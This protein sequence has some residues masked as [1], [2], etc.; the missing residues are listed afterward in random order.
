MEDLQ[1][2][3][4]ADTEPIPGYRL[5]HPL[6][7]GGFGEVWKCEAPGGLLKAIKFVHGGTHLLDDNAPAEEELRAVERVKAIR[8][9]FMLTMERVESVGGELVIVMELAD[10]SL[11]ELLQ[12]C[13]KAGLPGIPR[14]ALLAYLREAAEVLDVMN[15]RHSLQHLD[16]KPRNLFLVSNHVKVG[17]FGLVSSLSGL[18]KIELAAITP[19]Y[20]SPEVFQGSISRHSDQYSLAIVYQELLTGTLP[21]V[22]K[23]ARQLLMAHTLSEPNLQPLPEC[24]RAIV[25]RAL[26][27]NPEERFPSCSDFLSALAAGR[28]EVVTTSTEFVSRTEPIESPRQETRR[29]PSVKTVQTRCAK[30]TGNGILHGLELISRT[31]L[32]EVWKGQDSNGSPRTIKVLFGGPNPG[33]A[34]VERLG[35]LRHPVLAP[36]EILQHSPGR[37][38]LSSPPGEQTLRDVLQAYQNE[39]QPGIPRDKL[40]DWLRAAAE[41]LFYLNQKYGLQ[42]LGLNPRCLLLDHDRLLLADFGIAQLVWLPVG[43]SLT[44]LNGRYSAPE[45][46]SNRLGPAA[47][48]YSLALIYHELLTGTLPAQRA[49]GLSLDR[50]PETDRPL[51]ARAL[52]ADP[53]QRWASAVDLITALEQVG[54]DAKV[55]LPVGALTK[56]IKP[57]PTRNMPQLPRAKPTDESGEL[58]RARF[59]T[60]LTVDLIRQRIETFRQQWNATLRRSDAHEFAFQMP[61]PRSLWQRWTGK[62]PGLDIQIGMGAANPSGHSGIQVRTEVRMDLIPRDC[63]RDQTHELLKV[64]GPLLV[65]SLRTHL[66]VGQNG[67]CQERLPWHY[68]LKLCSILDNQQLG[69]PIECQGKDIS[70]NGIG[71]YL[72]GQLPSSQV[73]LILPP[74][75][76]TPE[77]SIPARIVRVQGCG[78]GWYEVGAVLLPPDELPPEQEEPTEGESA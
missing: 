1:Y 18:G 56:R 40:L 48:Q 53:A 33:D 29:L 4:R 62:Q 42:H 6:G 65:E 41:G 50:L 77:M 46:A 47:D 34:G 52:H 69:P 39:G 9:P 25:A 17:D 26:A 73:M 11:A 27:K 36:I 55:M 59:G 35:M 16:I 75:P 28:S 23:N 66:Q 71:F 57:L 30:P 67:R 64:V 58:M 21:F 49:E 60:N 61:M 24:D 63:S 78:D 12:S 54:D 19:L 68:P 13:Q 20:A 45:L 2:L 44:A 51:I 74:T 37:L 32:S 70:L 8:H 22:G 31:P 15:T 43:Q 7:Q 10:N 72:P 38:V 14:E 5:I 76:Q 3:H